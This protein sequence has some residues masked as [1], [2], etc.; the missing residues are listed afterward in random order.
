MK[1]KLTVMT[2]CHRCKSNFE[3]AGYALVKKGWQD[4]REACD[5]CRVGCGFTYG[6]FRYKGRDINGK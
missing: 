4:V 3:D 5:Y 2:L 6:L 1:K